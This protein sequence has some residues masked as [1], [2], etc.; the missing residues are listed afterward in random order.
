MP[1]AK[2]LGGEQVAPGSIVA[3]RP[4]LGGQFF[5]FAFVAHHLQGALGLF[6]SGRD[7]RLHLGRGLFHFWREAHVAVIL[8]AGAGWDQAS[9]DDVFFEAAQV[10]DRALDGG[11]GKHA[12]GLLERRR[13]NERV[14]RQRRFG[15]AQQQRASGGWF[16]A[17]FDDAIVFLA[18]VELVELLLEQ[19]RGVAHVF[20]LHPA[21]HLANDHFDV[22]VVDVDTLQAIDFLDFVDQ[23]SL[24]FFF[25]QHGENV[26]RVERAVHQR[27]AGLH[28][29]AFLHVDVNAARHL[30]FLLGAVVVYHEDFALALGHFTELDGAIDF[31]DDGRL[32]RLA[33]FEQFDH[34]RQ[35]SRDVLGAGG[36]ARDLRQDVSREDRVAFLH[37]EVGTRGH[38]VALAG[39]ALDHDRGL[40]L[41]VGR[42]SDHVTRQAGDF[43]DLFVQRH[44]VLQV[45]ELHCAADFGDNREGVRIPL[46][47]DLAQL[48]VIAFV[49]LDLGAVDDRIALAFAILLVHDRDR[50]L[51]VH[52]DQVA[53][54]RFH[55]LQADEA[56][57]AVVLGI[58][59]RLLG[60]SRSRAADVEGTHRQ[61]GSR[62]ADGLRRDHAG[63][64]AKFDEPSGRQV[65]AVAHH[66]DAALRFAGQHGTDFHSLNA[67]RLNGSREVFGDFLVDIDHNVAVIVFDF[68]ERNAAHDAIAQRF[69]DF[70]GFDD[71]LHVDAVDGAAVVLADDYVLG[72]IDQT[73]R[74]VAGIGRLQR[75]V[76]QTL[77]GAVGGDEIFE[78][79]QPFTEVGRDRRLDDF[80][81]RLGHQSTHAGELADLLF[82]SAGAGIG[83]D[84]NRIEVAFFVA[85]LHLGEHFVRDFFRD[86]RPDFDH[87]VLA[88]AVGDG[89]VQILLLHVDYLFLGVADKNLLV[90]RNDHVVDADGQAGARREGEAERFDF[91]EH[92]DRGLEAEREIAIVDQRA[93]ALFLEQAIDVRH[94]LGQVIVQDRA[95]DGCIDKRPLHRNRL[96]VN[97]VLVVVGRGQVDQRTAVA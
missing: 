83:H 19:E 67:G 40:A 6:I 28:P 97:D 2:K 9:H 35:T 11:F 45:L 63:S 48:D 33:G 82:R 65:A 22:L 92:L 34:A 12:R 77:A 24:Q 5:G 21:H 29:L 36:F 90:V 4:L 8:H 94:A 23:V 91:V 15:D 89:A 93:N 47:H 50:A 68:F 25:A 86:P 20:H 73:P 78:H 81:G 38:Q 27:L 69:D 14:G 85:A 61:L 53:G 58:E 10:V 64:F 31:A 17:F 44:A 88:L 54:L 1:T 7:F 26:V 60:D 75:R 72:N 95:P 32:V 39:F 18:E 76:S 37:H 62:F 56:H 74:E 70:A 66:A 79:G 87:F 71:S 84:V 13:R 46:D 51:A 30:V 16:A 59:T 49:D 42:V 43:V 3:P 96:G 52:Y 55:C 80:A 41:F 57:G